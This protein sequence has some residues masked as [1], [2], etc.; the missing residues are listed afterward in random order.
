MDQKKK[1]LSDSIWSIAGLVFMNVVLQFGVYKLWN[2][3]VDSDWSGNVQSLI[4]LMNVCRMSASLI[5]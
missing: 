3:M 2:V 1:M 5:W 4:S